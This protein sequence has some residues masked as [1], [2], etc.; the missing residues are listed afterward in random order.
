MKTDYMILP[1]EIKGIKEEEGYIYVDGYSSVYDVIDLG[2]DRVRPSFFVED[3]AKR[4]DQRPALWQHNSSEPV[5]IKIFKTDNYGLSFQ[6]KLPLDDTFV[7]GRVYPQLKIGS[8]KGVSIG[9]WTEKEEYN[10][11][12][13]CMDLIKGKLR[14]SS[15]VTFA[16]CEEATVLS[17]RKQ[18]KSILSGKSKSTSDSYN[19]DILSFVKSAHLDIDRDRTEEITFKSFPLADEKTNWNELEAIE[20]IKANTGSEDKPSRNYEKGFMFCDSDKKDDFKSFQLPYVKYIDGEFK[21]VPKAIYQIAGSINNLDLSSELKSE[22]KEHINSV[23]KK[24]GKEQPFTGEK[25]FVDTATLNNIK[26]SDLNIIFESNTTLSK[27]AK[28]TIIKSLRSPGL[29][30][31]V[32]NDDVDLLAFLKQANKD[33]EIK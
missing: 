12:L 17:V 32:T 14:E 21:I 6:A 2:R 33:M 24:L 29:D 13:N 4:G 15:F 26:K 5:G 20:E 8:V 11:E 9:Y 23:Y 7:T 31:S 19:Q 10:K 18:A 27:N 3:L 25:F 1:C 30:G 28:E 22:L 16:M